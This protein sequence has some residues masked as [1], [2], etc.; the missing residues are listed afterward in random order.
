ML[1]VVISFLIVLILS[2]HLGDQ[3]HAPLDKSVSHVV[4]TASATE[5]VRDYSGPLRNQVHFSP[6][7]NFMNGTKHR[8]KVFMMQT[9][10]VRS[11]WTVHR[12]RWDLPPLLSMCVIIPL[13][14]VA[15]E[16][17]ACQ[18]TPQLV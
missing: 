6:P 14:L 4:D 13:S 15:L 10:L 12:S 1:F 11:Q 9:N 18:T 7:Q 3:V 17:M 8:R 2:P 16:L 5:A